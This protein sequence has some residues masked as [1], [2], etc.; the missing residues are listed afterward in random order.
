MP[1]RPPLVTAVQWI[2]ALDLYKVLLYRSGVAPSVGRCLVT[3][4]ALGMV[5]GSCAP[6][7]PAQ[8]ALRGWLRSHPLTPAIR[9]LW[10]RCS[11]SAVG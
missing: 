10:R 7:V 5:F 3:A 2:C 4:A 9:V 6:M 8:R 11:C 1:H